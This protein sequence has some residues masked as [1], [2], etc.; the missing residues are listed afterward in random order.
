MSPQI[1]PEVQELK[2]FKPLNELTEQQLILVCARSNKKT[3]A[4]DVTLLHI[5]DNDMLEYFLLDGTV[6]L[7]SFDGRF[8]EISAK[9]DR[10]KTAIAL[11]QPRKYNVK[12][13]TECTFVI[14]D[15]N[16]V[17]TLLSERPGDQEVTFSV[18]DLHTGR[19]LENIY[20]SFKQDL[21][22]NN[23]ELP[24]FP[25]V[26]MNIRR[27]LSD[28]D[29]SAEKVADVLKND[30]AIT[31]KLLKVCNSPLYRSAKEITS[32]QEAIVR[33]GFE[34]TRQLVTVFALRELFKSKNSFLQ[35][36]MKELWVQSREVA[37]ISYILAK[38]T[39]GMNPEF[40]LLAGLLKDIGVIPVLIYLE[41]FPQFMKLENKVDQITSA[42][43][44]QVGAM[45]I[46]H[47]GLQKDFVE[48][49]RNSENWQYDSGTDIP[50]YSDITIVAQ[51]HAFIGRKHEKL[52]AFDEISAFKKLGN[53]GLTPQESQQ[54]LQES[55]QQLQELE[56]MLSP[57]PLLWRV[58][59]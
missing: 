45:L 24:S 27:V 52:P 6:E 12:T 42:L 48:I 11:L 47:W 4:P 9:T 57:S 17:N 34:T 33:L 50:T 23:I 44:K 53:G 22:S 2:R 1:S 26:A 8:T 51:L 3:F 14:V 43:K 7:E 38:H 36:K 13:K 41:R 54:V 37:A 31:L 29:V 59:G 18:S 28:P 21:A 5:G 10:S 25:D 46:E 32:N 55:K 19:E 58:R 20:Q 56:T 39:K 15:Q 16:T 49:A 35:N 40:A 30:P